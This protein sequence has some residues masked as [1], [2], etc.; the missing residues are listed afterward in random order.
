MLD[1]HPQ[2]YYNN[3]RRTLQ[4]K[5]MEGIFALVVIIAFLFIAIL[6]GREDVIRIIEEF[7]TKCARDCARK[8]FDYLAKR[9]SQEKNKYN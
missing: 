8:D 2:I 6:A 7:K 4:E 3:N 1:K 5:E 9:M